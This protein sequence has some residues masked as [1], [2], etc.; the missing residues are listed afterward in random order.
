MHIADGVLPA[1]VWG[2]GLALAAGGLVWSLKGIEA[3]RI[4]RLAVVTAA[5][6][7]ATLI[8]IPVG[9]SSV[10]LLL[11]GL[12]GIIAGRAAFACIFVSL[13]L[14]ALL[15]QFGGLLSLG[16]NSVV[17]GLPAVLAGL[18]FRLRGRAGLPASPFLFGLLAGGLAVVG[19]GLLLASALRLAGDEFWAAAGLVLLAHL[20]IVAIEA[21][22][23]GFTAAY[24]SRV[25]PEMVS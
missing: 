10:H 2:G 21:L 14:Q 11:T 19:N 3:D 7:V 5:A 9:P 25:K 24:L 15:F 20:P 17:M 12:V 18:F 8:H 1:P 22:V 16:V 13:T 23:G 6:F 4:P